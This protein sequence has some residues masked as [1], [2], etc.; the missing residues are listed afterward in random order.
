MK[1]EFPN[2]RAFN[3]RQSWDFPVEEMG[4]EGTWAITV[5]VNSKGR[6]TPFRALYNNPQVSVRVMHV[7]GPPRAFLVGWDEVARMARCVSMPIFRDE[8][9]DVEG[10]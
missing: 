10:V 1:Q 2:A 4:A 7:S 9:I 6:E 5:A 8:V 3:D